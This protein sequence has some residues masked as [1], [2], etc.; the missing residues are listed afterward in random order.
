MRVQRLLEKCRSHPDIDDDDSESDSE[1]FNNYFSNR[2]DKSEWSKLRKSSKLANF[3]ITERS[4]CHKI[5]RGPILHWSK[6]I[7]YFH[8]YND[9]ITSCVLLNGHLINLARKM[10]FSIFFRMKASLV[11]VKS[12]P[13]LFPSV[14]IY[15][16]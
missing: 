5:F 4:E 16:R 2:M 1:F 6:S 3:W 12:D 8:L 15:I 14:L 7:F 13:I 11:Q 10:S 9:N